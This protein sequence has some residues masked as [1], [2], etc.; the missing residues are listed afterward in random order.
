M[1][2][3]PLVREAQEVA[4][5]DQTQS[6]LPL[7]PK[8]PLETGSL[9]RASLGEPEKL[10]AEPGVYLALDNAGR[11]WYVGIAESIR[12]RLAAHDRTDDFRASHVTAIAWKSVQEPSERRR[13]E[14]DLIK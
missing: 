9:G 6:A 3:K 10:P 7:L 12:A 11:V 2:R 8:P 14:S 4:M 5:H 1:P 13:L